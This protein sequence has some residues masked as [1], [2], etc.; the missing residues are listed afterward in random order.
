MIKIIGGYVRFNGKT[1][2]KE[3]E[4]MNMGKEYEQKLVRQGFAKY[5]EQPVNEPIQPNTIP[6]IKKQEEI[7][8][9][10]ELSTKMTFEALK[11]IALKKG[12]TEKELIDEKGKN[13]TKAKVIELIESKQ[14]ESADEEETDET[15]SLDNTG[16]VV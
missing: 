11:K 15:F 13:I 9:E 4:P 1:Y 8:D 3:S 12:I 10:I 16:D 14:E 2:L 5:V 6:G 7:T